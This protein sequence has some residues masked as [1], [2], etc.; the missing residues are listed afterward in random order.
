MKNKSK[1]GEKASNTEGGHGVIDWDAVFAAC[2]EAG[3]EWYI[4]EQ[5][6]QTLPALESIKV[7]FE[8]F[9][10]RGIV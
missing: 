2:E 5:N 7:S 3:V 9:K 4:V 10:S 8:F 1:P 6:C